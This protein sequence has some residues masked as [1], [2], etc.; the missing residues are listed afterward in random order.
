VV[1]S[2]A[3]YALTGAHL[4]SGLD[5]VQVRL[6]SGP[7]LDA[8][9]IRV[10]SAQDVALIQLPGRRFACARVGTDPLPA[11]GVD[12]FAV[13]S[14]LGRDLDWSVSRG[15]VSGIRDFEGRSFVQTDVSV[16]PGNS[17]G[18]LFDRQARVIGVV[19]FKISGIGIE[20]LGFGVPVSAAERTLRL[21]FD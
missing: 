1:V 5:V 17:G 13:G 4:V 2:P 10:D 14:P 7:E 12:V 19:S 11:V 21:S 16:N 9:V 8:R 15:I 20:G 3:G 18:P 6:R